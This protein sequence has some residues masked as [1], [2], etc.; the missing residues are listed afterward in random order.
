MLD[1]QF[2]FNRRNI[3]TAPAHSHSQSEGGNCSIC[4]ETTGPRTAL[5]R[6][7]KCGHLF[8]HKCAYDIHT[9]NIKACPNCRAKPIRFR[10]HDEEI[11]KVIHMAHEVAISRLSTSSEYDLDPNF[12]LCMTPYRPKTE[13]RCLKN[14]IIQENCQGIKNYFDCG[15]STEMRLLVKLKKQKE[16]ELYDLLGYSIL[17][18][19]TKV[20]AFLIKSRARISI[21]H[22][23]KIVKADNLPLAKLLVKTDQARLFDALCQKSITLGASSITSWLFESGLIIKKHATLKSFRTAC[24]AGLAE[25]SIKLFEL[26]ELEPSQALRLS[27][28]EPTHSVFGYILTHHFA[29][30]IKAPLFDVWL[31]ATMLRDP[32]LLQNLHSQY[33]DAPL[34]ERLLAWIDSES[35]RYIHLN[36][37]KK[38]KTLGVSFDQ[39]PYLASALA[40]TARGTFPKENKKVIEFLLQNGA[41]IDE[42]D[43]TFVKN[44]ITRIKESDREIGGRA[45]ERLLWSSILS[46][47][48]G[49]K[50]RRKSC[51]CS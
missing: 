36:I 6:Q 11:P 25:L 2:I 14:W 29:G 39:A 16:P 17:K 13:E 42:A 41:E 34:G 18:K 20:S 21:K 30:D 44:Q 23:T 1:S 32:W 3:L 49:E 40:R 35:I 5:I 31:H 28:R 38:M 22:I 27:I 46:K 50:K 37:F 15:G 7:T 47:V 33:P 24:Q 10:L 48:K 4:L 8:H 12:P 26:G 45:D 19:K 51:C 9:N 43:V